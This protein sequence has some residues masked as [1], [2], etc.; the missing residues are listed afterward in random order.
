MNHRSVALISLFYLRLPLTCLHFHY[1]LVF[2]SLT[3]L[4]S[5][6]DPS[7]DVPSSIDMLIG[8]DLLHHIMKPLADILQCQGLPSALD[9]FL[10]WVVFGL[11]EEQNS[12]YAHSLSVTSSSLNDMIQSFWSVEEITQPRIPT[13]DQQCAK[14]FSETTTRDEH[15]NYICI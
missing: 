14:W 7:F 11:F 1:F 2:V 10:G 15:S 12:L 4:R 13:E 5:L 3:V 9:S 8:G 6:A